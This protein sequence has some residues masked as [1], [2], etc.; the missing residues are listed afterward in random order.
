MMNSVWE[1]DKIS[2]RSEPNLVSNFGLDVGA[3]LFPITSNV[4]THVTSIS[5]II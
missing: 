3:G 1:V 5:F 2:F 4:A